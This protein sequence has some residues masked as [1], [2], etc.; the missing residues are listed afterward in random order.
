MSVDVNTV[1][2]VECYAAGSDKERLLN[3]AKQKVWKQLTSF[4][5]IYCYSL[6]HLYFT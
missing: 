5:N 2:L 1:T 4:P 6:I 3:K